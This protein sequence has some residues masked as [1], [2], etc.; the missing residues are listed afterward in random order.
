MGT[1]SRIWLLCFVIGL[2]GCTYLRQMV[3]LIAEKPEVK[4]TAV[5][6]KSFSMKKVDLVFLLDI[7]NPNGFSMRSGQS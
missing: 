3:G 6:V 2:A 1:R 5:D 7:F 4:L